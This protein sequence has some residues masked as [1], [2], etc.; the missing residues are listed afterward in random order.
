MPVTSTSLTAGFRGSFYRNGQKWFGASGWD[1][2]RNTTL[3]EDGVLDQKVTIPVEQSLTY[4]LK[5]SELI[6][7][8]EF[9]NEVLI[10][11]AQSIQL[12]FLFIGE[13]RRNDGQ[14][15]RVRMVG[16]C[17]SADLLI[18][19]VTRGASR[20]RDTTFRL[21]TV[22]SFDTAISGQALGEQGEVA[23]VT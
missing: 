21:D 16:A 14:I 8:S 11:D 10:A 3:T 18:S 12:R 15:E 7:D 9:S 6:L 5:V 2:T 13:T 22:P 19:G 17:I 23:V 1:L 20:K 4:T